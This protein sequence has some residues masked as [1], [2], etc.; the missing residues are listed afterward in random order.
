MR[1]AAGGVQRIRPHLPARRIARPVAY[2]PGVA[3]AGVGPCEPRYGTVPWLDLAEIRAPA[4]SP[5]RAGVSRRTTVEVGEDRLQDGRSGLCP[6]E[7]GR[8]CDTV[9]GGRSAA[10]PRS[11]VRSADPPGR[12]AG[13]SGIARSVGCDLSSSEPAAHG[14]LSWT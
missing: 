2:R 3:L 4:G 8:G 7:P 1:P 5:E 11:R 14:G 6:A 10:P 12:A 9:D 13:H